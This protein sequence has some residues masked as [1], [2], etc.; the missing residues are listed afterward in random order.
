MM[1]KNIQVLKLITGEEVVADVE[2]D[3]K[4]YLLNDRV[5]L[6][7]QQG[8][9]G[10]GQTIVPWGHSVK[11]G[12]FLDFRNVMYI[13]TPTQELLDVYNK[14]FSPLATPSKSLLIG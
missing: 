14:A 11:G 6:I 9:S 12:I 1:T 3:D 5:Q 8:P 4:G 10:L 13:G 2:V 7:M